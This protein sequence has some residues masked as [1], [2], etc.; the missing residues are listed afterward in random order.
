M[1]SDSRTADALMSATLVGCFCFAVFFIYVAKKIYDAFESTGIP[2][3]SNGKV[4]ATLDA[5][6]VVA[7][8]SAIALLA[9]GL[10]AWRAISNIR[11]NA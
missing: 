1:K 11:R 8:I 2:V 9:A 6:P 10:I 7:G 3:L 5:L 4:I